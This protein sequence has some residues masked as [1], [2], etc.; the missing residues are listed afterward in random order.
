MVRIPWIICGYVAL[1]VTVTVFL[2]LFGI[3]IG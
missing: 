2:L 3:R 1:M